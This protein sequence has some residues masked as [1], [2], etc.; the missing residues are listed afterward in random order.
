MMIEPMI[1]TP[2]RRNSGNQSQ[3][4]GNSTCWNPDFPGGRGSGR[5][6]RACQ[7]R[8]SAGASPSQFPGTRNQL[9]RSS[10]EHCAL[11][12]NFVRNRNVG[13]TPATKI[14]TSGCTFG[15]TIDSNCL[16]IRFSAQGAVHGGVTPDVVT[17]GIYIPRSPVGLMSR[18]HQITRLLRLF[19]EHGL[20]LKLKGT[21]R[22]H[23]TAKGRRTLPAFIAARNAS[24]GQLAN[25]AA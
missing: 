11:S 9:A 25:L 18:A 10:Q 5:A 1:L 22:Y 4:S 17:W 12:T 2:P 16:Q 14:D 20:I 21:H 7:R 6:T 3:V 15:R 23:L 8:G 13:S 19:W 24:A